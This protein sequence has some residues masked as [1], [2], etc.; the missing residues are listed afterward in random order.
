MCDIILPTHKSQKSKTFLEKVRWTGN[1]R[2]IS[3]MPVAV[4]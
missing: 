2:K 1:M 4:S 3:K